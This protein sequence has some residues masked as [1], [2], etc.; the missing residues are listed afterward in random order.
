VSNSTSSRPYGGVSADERLAARRQRL[1]D[2]GLEL[3]GTRGIAATS[4]ADVCAQAGL[5]KRYF[6]EGFATIEELAVA[7]FDQVVGRLAQQVAPAIAAGEGRDPRP[8]LTAHATAVLSDPRV[9]R[10]L[11]VESRTAALEERRR[12]FARRAVDLWFAVT[13][14][15]ADGVDPVMR[16]RAYA[17]AGALAEIGLA[18]IQGELDLTPE[19]VIDEL[20]DLF[21]RISDISR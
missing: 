14:G 11:T 2:A 17:Y 15:G 6:Y 4:I 3:F 16:L 12:G 18:S 19:Q 13:G 21:H 1:L 8:A 20:V 10:L 7:V 5:T 9:V